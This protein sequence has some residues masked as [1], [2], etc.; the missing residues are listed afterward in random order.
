[1][2]VSLRFICGVAA[3]TFATVGLAAQGA[4]QTGDRKEDEKEKK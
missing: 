3:L 1:M 4:G 2:N